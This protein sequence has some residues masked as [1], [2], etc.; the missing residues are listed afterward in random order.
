MTRFRCGLYFERLRLKM[1]RYDLATKI[2]TEQATFWRISILL[3]A[4]WY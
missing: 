2:L 3:N 1:V 4:H